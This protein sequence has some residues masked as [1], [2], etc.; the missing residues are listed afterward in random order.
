MRYLFVGILFLLVS[1]VTQAK[2]ITARSFVLADSQ[3]DVLVEKYS[4]K[5][6]PIAS[7]TKLMTVI[8]VLNSKQPLT[9]HLLLDFSLAAKYH[10]RLPRNLKSLTR[11]ELIQL[12]LVKS[13]NF[14]AYTLCQNYLGGID[15]CVRDMNR[16]A[17]RL[18]MFHTEFTDPTGLDSGNISTAS[19]LVKLVMA[20]GNY[21]KIVEFSSR[22]KVTI[23][24]GNRLAEFNNTNPMVRQGENII[25]SKT[26]FINSSGGCL[27]MMLLTNRGPRI[28]VVL[29]SRNTKTRVPEARMILAGI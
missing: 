8:V 21:P 17:Q 9:E 22:P 24:T 23:P 7:I 27:A 25:V 12:A 19:D 28:V 10:T 3:G 5:I 16:E 14:A 29:G 15:S 4:D 6:Q 2:I 20:A 26:G 11:E 18:S 13:D 1:T